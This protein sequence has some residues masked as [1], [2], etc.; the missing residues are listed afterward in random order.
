MWEHT[1]EKEKEEEEGDGGLQRRGGWAGR[2]AGT[3]WP[4]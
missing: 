3:G 1:E 2:E 4:S